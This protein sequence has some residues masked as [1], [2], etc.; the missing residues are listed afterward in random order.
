MTTKEFIEQIQ[1]LDASNQCKDRTIKSLNIALDNLQFDYDTML[2]HKNQEITQLTVAKE[3]ADSQLAGYVA[4][5]QELEEQVAR[6]EG[7]LEHLEIEYN[8]LHRDRENMTVI[9]SAL[10]GQIDA[11]RKPPSERGRW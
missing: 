6:L 3:A 2:L 7:K 11:M 8:H 5:A 4:F 1:M 10:N 9:I